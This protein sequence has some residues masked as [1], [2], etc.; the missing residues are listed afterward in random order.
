MRRIPRLPL[1]ID[2]AHPAPTRHPRR[3]STTARA[4]AK[5]TSTP[6]TERLRT[7]IW[8]TDHAPGRED[9]YSFDSPLRSEQP[10]Q[11]PRRPPQPAAVSEQQQQQGPKRPVRALKDGYEPAKT[12]HGL[13]WVGGEKWAPE[14][15]QVPPFVAADVAEKTSDK[16]EITAA[17]RRA[18]VEVYAARSNGD[19]LEKVYNRTDDIS[20]AFKLK[21]AKDGS[22]VITERRV[23]DHTA[24]MDEVV[25]QVGIS[26]GEI[27]RWKPVSLRDPEIKFAVV[28]RVMQLTGL[29]ISDPVIA[30]S[31][32][33][34]ILLD[35][36]TAREQP[37]KLAERLEHNEQ[38]AKLPNV[39]ISRRRITPI[40]KEKE[41]GRWK[42]IEQKLLDKNLP[43]TGHEI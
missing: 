6:F 18:L 34:G 42:V 29:R 28:K 22:A 30:R 32:T 25:E 24:S 12:W 8:G 11:P 35:Q 23:E 16:Q 14:Q 39:K 38:L 26:P 40:D 37:K 13:E 41:V 27:K 31:S 4:A 21:A 20:V 2:L 7:K 9:P 3:I 10:P 17:L 1:P 15:E 36:I 43:V 19:S 33:A 5:S